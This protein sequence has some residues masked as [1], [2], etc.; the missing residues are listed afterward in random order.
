MSDTYDLFIN[1]QWTQSS[2]GEYFASYNPATGK[3][4]A[5][6]ARGTV[7]DAER[8]VH[9]AQ[10]AFQNPRWTALS[11]S[12]RGRLLWKLADLVSEHAERLALIETTDNGKLL[13]ETRGLM[14][15]LPSFY[16][17]FAGIAD[18][19][20]GDVIP[21][22]K[23]DMFVFSSREPV[24]VVLAIIPWNSPS[25]LLALK[26]AP[27][28]AAGNT[29]IIKPSEHASAVVLEMAR[30]CQ[31]AGF[32][33]GVINVVTG[34][35][36]LGRH[37]VEHS[38]IDK[39]A[40]TGGEEIA[41][42]I[43][44][45]SAK[46]LAK[47][48][49]EL[50]G[51]SPN[52]VFQDANVDNAAMGLIA[53]IFAA[54]GQSC[55]AGSRAYVHESVYPEL[56]KK[57]VQRTERI[58]IGDPTDDGSEMGPIGTEQQ[59]NKI[60]SSIEVA[61]KQGAHLEYGGH[62]PPERDAGWY[63][64]PTIL[65]DVSPEAIMTNNEVF[66]PVLSVY[67]FRE[68]DEVLTLANASDYGLAAGV[69]TTDSARALRVAN[70]IRAGIVWVNCYR[71]ISPLAPIGGSRRSGYGREGGWESMYEYTKTK[72]V[73]INTSSEAIG[74]PFVMR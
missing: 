10:Q 4:W 28:I 44:R 3:P 22:D 19:V 20:T 11:G 33:P 29:I 21:I 34:G 1:G 68:E 37:L 39:I 43:V 12:D 74:D 14:A 61:L 55:V 46:N 17:Y 24:G 64:Q 7:E 2:D 36:D 72:T 41:R 40:F 73:W 52:I 9:S 54:S 66:G 16:R 25:Y 32:P 60:A 59:L 69:W 5:R 71:S 18:K 56:V 15:Y 62:Q 31:M 8:A 13:R 58:R 35:P 67:Q 38:G 48:T 45:G 6:I 27:A 65:S 26:L 57:I 50:G 42:D 63:F 30:L 70:R 23:P 47:L 51:K 53:G 49:L